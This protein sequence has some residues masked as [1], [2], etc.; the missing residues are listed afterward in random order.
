MPAP[1]TLP[2]LK[3][4]IKSL[5]PHGASQHGKASLGQQKNLCSLI[6]IECLKI[7]LVASRHYHKVPVR[8]WIFIHD[9]IRMDA[10]VQNQILWSILL[11]EHF[12]EHT[13]LNA[14]AGR[15]FPP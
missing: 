1:A 2:K 4:H 5:R 13:L 12:A 14:V 11:L 9:Y 3:S 8:V 15:G 7:L 10:T 6:W